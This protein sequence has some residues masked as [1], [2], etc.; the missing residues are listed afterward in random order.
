[1]SYQ[2]SDDQGSLHLSLDAGLFL[3]LA[4]LG[5]ALMFVLK[6]FGAPQAWVTGS[7]VGLVVL[8]SVVMLVVKRLRLRLDQAGDNAYYLGLVFT[9]CSM[10]SALWEIGQRVG[11]NAPSSASAAE[12]VIGDFGLALFTTLAGIVC[13][14]VLHQMRRD[15]GDVEAQGRLELAQ[16]ATRMRF[17]LNDVTSEFGQFLQQLKQKQEDHSKELAETHDL[18]RQHI[19]DSLQEAVVQS[20]QSLVT[21]TTGVSGCIDALVGASE[22]GATALSSAA[23]RLEAIEA[24]PVRLSKRYTAMADNV[25]SIAEQLARTSESLGQSVTNIQA[26][27]VAVERVAHDAQGVA[28]HVARQLETHDHRFQERVEAMDASVA[29]LAEHV[30]TLRAQVRAASGEAREAED[31][32]GVAQAAAARVLDGLADVVTHIDAKLTRAP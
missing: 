4:L 12:A 5:I 1:M 15:P 16:A 23:D 30:A 21:A 7:V 2:G 25:E 31:A 10:A 22:R 13:R 32:V 19:V 28:P 9:L 20:Q 18:L 27:A 8:Y 29:G 24:P 11:G 14:I 3:A 17:I 26:A 6:H